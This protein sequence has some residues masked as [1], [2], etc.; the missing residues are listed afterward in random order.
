MA[1]EAPPLRTT[2]SGQTTWVHGACDHCG[3]IVT[4]SIYVW[5][6]QERHYCSVQCAS[7]AK[8]AARPLVT[9]LQCGDVVERAP[10]HLDANGNN[11]CSRL[12]F[13]HWKAGR[14]QLDCHLERLTAQRIA[15]LESLRDEKRILVRLISIYGVTPT[16]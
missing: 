4:R 11:F 2:R 8:A 1:S 14:S 7:L 6:K 16:L 3:E 15:E 9:C 10:T 12:C 5:R 13:G